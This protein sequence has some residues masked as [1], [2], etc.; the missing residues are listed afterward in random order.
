AVHTAL[1][2]PVPQR[3]GPVPGSR[4]RLHGARDLVRPPGRHGANTRTRSGGTDSVT[5]SPAASLAVLLMCRAWPPS[6]RT[7]AALSLPWY[8]TTS[9]LPCTGFGASSPEPTTVKS[10]GRMHA[11]AVPGT[12]SRRTPVSV[13]PS[14][15]T[16][17]VLP[18]PPVTGS[19]RVLR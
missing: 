5:R 11:T 9:T 12:S 4:R 15:P 3:G 19:S 1:G 7:S 13:S 8:S 17:T 16:V 6:V 2:Q 18:S 14:P 10:S